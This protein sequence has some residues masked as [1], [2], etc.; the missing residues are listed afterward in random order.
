MPIGGC[1]GRISFA[2]ALWGLGRQWGEWRTVG[3]EC[4]TSCLFE[5]VA[6]HSLSLVLNRLLYR[7]IGMTVGIEVSFAW[8]VV[9]GLFFPE[10]IS[11]GNNRI[12][13]YNATVLAHEHL[14]QEWRVGPV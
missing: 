8:E 6:R 1:C 13:G 3:R 7:A 11:V 14:L 10:L 12:I 5:S 4:G 9:P 2:N